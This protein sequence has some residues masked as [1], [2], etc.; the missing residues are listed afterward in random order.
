MVDS[1]EEQPIAPLAA[2]EEG[3][4]TPPDTRP[5]VSRK[6]TPGSVAFVP[7]VVGMILAG[8]VVKDLAKGK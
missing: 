6:V 4:E 5:G 2:P 7:P 8:E 1:L 3:E